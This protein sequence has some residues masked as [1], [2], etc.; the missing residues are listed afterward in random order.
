VNHYERLKVSQDAPAE[1]IRAAYRALAAKLHPDKQGAEASPG[2]A[3]HAV[4]A[5]LNA[6]Y[7]VL[8]DPKLRQDYDA[9][10]A[11][12]RPLIVE[13][14]DANVDEGTQAPSSRVDMN[15][16]APPVASSSTLWPPSKRV[17]LAGGGALG[18]TIL[19]AST[20]LWQVKGQHDV[21]LALSEQYVTQTVGRVDPNVQPT[22]AVQVQ[23]ER[24]SLEELSRMSDE[25][26]L[27]AL[28]EMDKDTPL[29]KDSYAPPV[30]T[31]P[32]PTRHP[33][34]GTPLALRVEASLVDP[35]A[36]AAPS[37]P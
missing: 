10:L 27:K 32:V 20:L 33:L 16:K 14:P 7:E 19:V 24:P 5:S 6:A 11:P 17:M 9:T 4:M 2:D 8:I 12:A 35:L 21:D 26:L 30:K 3:T 37:K 1:V 28:P 31:R 18:V 29:T 15:W 34:D 25:E 36:P 22:Q 13:K 23:S